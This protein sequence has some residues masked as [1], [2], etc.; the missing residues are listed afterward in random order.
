M[1]RE[2]CSKHSTSAFGVHIQL[3]YLL[4]PHFLLSGIVTETMASDLAAVRPSFWSADFIL[5]TNIVC[6]FTKLCDKDYTVMRIH[7]R[8]WL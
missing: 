2:S 5:V 4:P 6:E 7:A 1:L 8:L 3:K